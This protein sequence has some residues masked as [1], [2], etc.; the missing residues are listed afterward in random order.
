MTVKKAIEV[1]ELAMQHYQTIVNGITELVSK[2]EDKDDM[3]SRMAKMLVIEA[4]Q[5]IMV[6]KLILKQIKPDCKHL[7][8]Y[9]DRDS[10]GNWYCTNC[11]LDL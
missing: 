3:P 2:W 8:K 11:N 7:K 4:E 6:L 5:S 9:R 10:K 1:I